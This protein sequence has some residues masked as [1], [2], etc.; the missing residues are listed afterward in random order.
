MTSEARNSGRLGVGFIVNKKAS[1]INGAYC[2]I[3]K[4]EE[5]CGEMISSFEKIEIDSKILCS[6]IP[7]GDSCLQQQPSSI[8]EMEP[9]AAPSK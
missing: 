8:V 1:A 7:T 4:V 5:G 6:L 3:N 9:N 2:Y